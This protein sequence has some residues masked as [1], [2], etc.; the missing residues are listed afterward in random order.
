MWSVL[1]SR[2]WGDIAAAWALLFAALHLYWGLG[3]AWGLAESAGARLAAER[4]L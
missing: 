4:P 3:G 2:R 1:V